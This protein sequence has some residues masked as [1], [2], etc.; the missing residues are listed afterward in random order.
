MEQRCTTLDLPVQIIRFKQTLKLG[1]SMYY[2]SCLGYRDPWRPIYNKSSSHWD[3]V[4]A[5]C[6]RLQ[7]EAKLQSVTL[8]FA[9]GKCTTSENG[10]PLLTTFCISFRWSNRY[11]LHCRISFE[12]LPRSLKLGSKTWDRTT[13]ISINSRTLYLL[14][15]LGIWSRDDEER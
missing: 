13:D 14:R 5:C 6:F 3:Q 11:L 8:Y 9:F 2:R 15:Y 12:A 4:Q 1:N 7:T 10:G